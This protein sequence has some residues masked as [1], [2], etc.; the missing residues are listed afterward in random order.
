MKAGIMFEDNTELEKR[1]SVSFI[2]ETWCKYPSSFEDLSVEEQEKLEAQ[3]I[4]EYDYDNREITLDM[5]P[6]SAQRRLKE[7]GYTTEQFDACKYLIR[8]AKRWALETGLP[9]K[10]VMDSKELGHWKWLLAFTRVVA[11]V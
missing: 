11:N 1:L 3:G 7:L 8:R 6:F 2:A 9:Y 10:Y 4:D 5:L